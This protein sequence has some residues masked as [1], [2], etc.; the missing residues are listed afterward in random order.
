MRQAL[1]RSKCFEA[2]GLAQ[3]QSSATVG[4]DAAKSAAF[5]RYASKWMSGRV[6]I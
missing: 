4:K 1:Q 6:F 5:D 2:G 3:T